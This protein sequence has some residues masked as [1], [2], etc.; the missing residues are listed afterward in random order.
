M[1]VKQRYIDWIET[2]TNK[3]VKSLNK[4]EHSDQLSEFIGED[5]RQELR[6]IDLQ[7]KYKE[8]LKIF[9]KIKKTDPDNKLK[10]IES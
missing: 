10:E 5:K 8:I 6:L 7:T 4:I 9:Y 2:F 3:F 1:Q